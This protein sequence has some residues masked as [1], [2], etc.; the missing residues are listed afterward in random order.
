[1]K[2]QSQISKEKLEKN[3][4]KELEVIV[5]GKSLDKK[6]LI[7]RTRKDVPDIDGA[8]YIKLNN[9][10]KNSINQ[11]IKCKV[12]NVKEYDLIAE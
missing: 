1:M 5:E 4:G 9:K 2:I 8:T 11:I 6:Y 7:G 12:T 10:N 3:I